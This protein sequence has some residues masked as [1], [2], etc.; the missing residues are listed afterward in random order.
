[1]AVKIE[2]FVRHVHHFCIS[3]PHT[4]QPQKGSTLRLKDSAAPMQVRDSTAGSLEDF[5]WKDH[6]VHS[7]Q[8]ISCLD[9][10]I[11]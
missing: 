11:R 8:Q 9:G 10:V 4:A 2:L 5:P 6:T 1:M 7:Y 3:L